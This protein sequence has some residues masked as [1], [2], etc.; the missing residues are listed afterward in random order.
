MGLHRT[1]GAELVALLTLMALPGVGLK[2]LRWLLQRYGSARTALRAPATELGAPAAAAR[3]APATVQRVDGA[4]RVIERGSIVVLMQA[5][6][7]Y[8]RRF[9]HVADPPPV[10]F[11]RGDLSLLDLPAVAVVGSRDATERG[12]RAA[13]ELGRTLAAAGAAVVSGF[14]RGID[15]AAH[16]G[17]LDASGATIAVLGAGIDVPYPRPHVRLHE[18]LAQHGLLLS[19]F[20]PGELPYPSHFPRRNRLIA[21]QSAAVICVEAAEPSGALGTVGHA[22]D[23]GRSVFVLRATPGARNTAGT[24]RLIQDGAPVL[25]RTEDVLQDDFELMRLIPNLE[26]LRAAADAAGP[27]VAAGSRVVAGEAGA[28]VYSAI[29]FDPLH[30]DRIA[31]IAEVEPATALSALLELEVD[32]RV[33]QLPGGWYVRSPEL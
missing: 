27:R 18:R 24:N 2:R 23:I 4:L 31:A 29:G 12:R 15:A 33:C 25:R 13:R 17:A 11:A 9:R 21:A 20:L 10:V 16:R 22:L 26:R 3:R 7:G 1:D 5:D 6:A 28:R 14:A 32:G 30:V 8:P 19:E